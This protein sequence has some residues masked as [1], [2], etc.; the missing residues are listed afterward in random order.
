MDKC[1]TLKINYFAVNYVP[2]VGGQPRKTSD[3]LVKGVSAVT[4]LSLKEPAGQRGFRHCGTRGYSCP[5]LN[6][7]QITEG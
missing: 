4:Q 6:S 7:V 5:G 2:F 1:Q 3:R